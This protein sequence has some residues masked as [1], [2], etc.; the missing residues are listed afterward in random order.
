MSKSLIGVMQGRLLPKYKGR[1][2]AHPVAYW[3]DEFAIASSLDLDLIEWI[4]DFNEAEQNPIFSENGIRGIQTVSTQ[5]GVHVKTVC[6]DYFMEAP[7][8]SA[9]ARVADKSISVLRTL[10]GTCHK[11]GVENIVIPCVDQSTIGDPDDFDRL[12]TAMKAV[13]PLAAKAG[14]YL[15]LETDLD[16]KGFAALIGAID[17]PSVTVNYDTGNSASLGYVPTEEL[18]AYGPRISDIHIKD[19]KLKGGSVPLG[20]GDT[21]FDDFFSALAPLNY[22]GPFIMQAY[23]DDEGLEIFRAQLH[24]A[25]EQ[26]QHWGYR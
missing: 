15:C 16:P 14:I 11:L 19:R 5:T 17:L 2:Q 13:G 26:L 8:H 20:S 9:A 1:Y 21:K 24:W 10:L 18:T 4:F 7:L 6:A 3:Q 23:R 12:V 22:K 25:I